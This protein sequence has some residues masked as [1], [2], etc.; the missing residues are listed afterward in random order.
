M[1]SCV[2][3]CLAQ[4]RVAERAGCGELHQNVLS[5]CSD[6]DNHRSLVV[7]RDPENCLDNCD[8]KHE[9]LSCVAEAPAPDDPVLDKGPAGA[10][11]FPVADGTG[12]EVLCIE[13]EGVTEAR[14]EYARKLRDISDPYSADRG[15]SEGGSCDADWEACPGSSI[16]VRRANADELDDLCV[17]GEFYLGFRDADD[18]SPPGDSSVPGGSGGSGG[19]VDPGD[20]SD[21]SGGTSGSGGMPRICE[22]ALPVEQGAA[23]RAAADYLCDEQGD[24]LHA[25][26]AQD[27]SIDLDMIA[28]GL[29]VGIVALAV[30]AGPEFNYGWVVTRS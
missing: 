18:S 3:S 21:G 26:A 22:W 8:S 14:C 13:G 27:S 23:A 25:Q 1:P 2:D 30:D 17:L 12:F 4:A 6:G 9:V 20:G 28:D 10:C 7:C 15:F 11:E 5:C 24:S 29:G 19:A 16:V